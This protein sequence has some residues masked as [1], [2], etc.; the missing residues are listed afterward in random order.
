VRHSLADISLARSLLGYEPKVGLEEGLQLT[1][2]WWQNNG[3]Y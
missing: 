2:D 1:F 3:G